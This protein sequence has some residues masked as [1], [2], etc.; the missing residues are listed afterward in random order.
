MVTSSGLAPPPK[1]EDMWNWWNDPLNHKFH[2]CLTH[3]LKLLQHICQVKHKCE[4]L[5]IRSDVW[6]R[7]KN[8]TILITMCVCVC[9]V[10][11]MLSCLSGDA[12]AAAV[13]CVWIQPT[14]HDTPTL[15]TGSVNE[16]FPNTHTYTQ[17][18][19]RACVCVSSLR[20]NTIRMIISLQHVCQWSH[21]LDSLQV[22]SI[23]RF[24]Q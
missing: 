5:Y 3:S 16:P 8:F 1:T 14:T 2:F 12:D 4:C 20:L 15:N 21:T 9:V 18:C 13:V 24:S 6:R 10:L 7:G 11:M 23:W 22:K 19:L 17:Q